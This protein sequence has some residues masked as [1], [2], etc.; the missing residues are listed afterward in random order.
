MAI[1]A[2]QVNELRKIT[3]AG[4]M[5]CKKALVG[6][7]GN[8]EKAIEIL[9]KKGQKVS[10][11]RADRQT[12]EGVV[13]AKVK[14]DCSIGIL[15]SLTCE[16]DFV[17]KN[18]DFL[19]LAQSII[20]VAFLNL[21]K[22]INTLLELEIDGSP[23]KECIVN[24]IGKIGEKL[25]ISAYQLLKAEAVHSYIHSNKKLGVLVGLKNAARGNI[26]EAGSNV[27]MQI[28]AMKPIAVGKH[29][30]DPKILEREMEIGKEQARAEGKPEKI[31]DK[32]ANGKVQKFL[33]DNTLL[34]Q[35]FIKDNSISVKKYLEGIN[36]GLTVSSF[37]RISIGD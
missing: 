2:K 26:S 31:L 5:D 11:S 27:A 35:T 21:P 36:N 33:K 4:M 10:A 25:E 8:V 17:A 12:S 18:N 34:E 16:T 23:I 19:E 32:I 28:A 29:D 22:D 15:I 7:D 14:D 3:G 1:T 24:T 6:A 20:D 9:R 30:I 37:N 13:L